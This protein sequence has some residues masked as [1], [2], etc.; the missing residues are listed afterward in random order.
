LEL[1]RF[2]IQI[3]STTGKEI[4]L[5]VLVGGDYFGE[6]AVLDPAPR[7]ASVMALQASRLA[8]LSREH[9]IHC[10]RAAGGG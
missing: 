5:G 1:D 10:I 9:V 6:L 3:W 4:V 7:S 2:D 8:V